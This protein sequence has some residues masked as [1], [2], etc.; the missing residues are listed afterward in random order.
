[1]RPPSKRRLSRLPSDDRRHHWDEA[2]GT[3]PTST[4]VRGHG[5]L[6]VPDRR[7]ENH[8]VDQL[9]RKT[10]KC[11][12]AFMFALLRP[13]RIFSKRCCVKAPSG[14]ARESPAL[15]D[16]RRRRGTIPRGGARAMHIRP[17]VVIPSY[18]SGSSVKSAVPNQ[19]WRRLAESISPATR[20]HSDALAGM[21][22]LY[23]VFPAPK[24]MVTIFVVSSNCHVP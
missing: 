20:M 12:I 7:F 5:T 11:S 9:N 13:H 1:M 18:S 22:S 2:R 8:R 19:L 17:S 3:W 21:T 16:S 14:I 10:K 15:F 4:I 6:R 24:S 23:D